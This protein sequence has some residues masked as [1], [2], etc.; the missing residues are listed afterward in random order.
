MFLVPITTGFSLFLCLN[1]VK[2]IGELSFI[3]TLLSILEF[4]FSLSKSKLNYSSKLNSQDAD[5]CFVWYLFFKKLMAM[6]MNSSSLGFTK[7][8]KAFPQTMWHEMYLLFLSK[9]ISFFNYFFGLFALPK[10]SELFIS[11]FYAFF[12]R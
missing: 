8:T 11:K 9:V 1:I 6:E 12:P 2:W 4:E 5:T 7:S 3:N 10:L